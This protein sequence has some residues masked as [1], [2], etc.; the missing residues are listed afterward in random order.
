MRQAMVAT[1]VLIGVAAGLVWADS[2]AY[3]RPIETVWEHALKA[4]RDVDFVVVDSKH[5]SYELVMRTKS[6]LSAKRGMEMQLTLEAAGQGA[7]TV[8]V[9]AVDP[10]DA[11][12]LEKPIRKYLAALDARLD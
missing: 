1:L 10:D 2:R 12:D 4:T 8:N 5:E 9:V 3:N 11:E 7:T 6:K